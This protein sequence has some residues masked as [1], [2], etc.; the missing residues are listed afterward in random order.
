[1]TS[2][3]VAI[4]PN[5]DDEAFKKFL[6]KSKDPKYNVKSGSPSSG[7]SSP[8]SSSG[9]P[10]STSSSPISSGGGSSGGCFIATAAYGSPLANSVVILSSFRD[11]YL[12]GSSFGRRFIRFY[13][14]YSPGIA[15]YIADRHKLKSIVRVLLMPLVWL[16]RQLD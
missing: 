16:C 1:M 4:T 6:E 8:I 5:P 7:S 11:Q 14:R 13:Y 3:M 9:A 15:H 10:F 12:Q 2:I